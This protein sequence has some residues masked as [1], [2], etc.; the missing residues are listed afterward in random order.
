MKLWNIKDG[1]N[2]FL[3]TIYKGVAQVKSTYKILSQPA[4][5]E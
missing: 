5:A 1:S 4:A 2:R 3:Q